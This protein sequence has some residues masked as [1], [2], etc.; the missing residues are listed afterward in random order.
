[1]SV[2]EK[3]YESI[4]KNMTTEEG[5]VSSQMFG[6]PCLKV[7]GK[8]FA[9]LHKGEVMVFKLTDMAHKEALSLSGAH[10]F[11]PGMGRP[12]KEWVVVP[13][14]YKDKWQHFAKEAKAYVEKL[15][16]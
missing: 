8:A 7:N 15:K 6:M 12:M 4:I 1:M 11:D 5:V 3:Q 10:L 2:P 9:G 16:K 14:E 13:V